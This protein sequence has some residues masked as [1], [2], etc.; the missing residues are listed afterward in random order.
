[1]LGKRKFSQLFP[2]RESLHAS[3]DW[4]YKSWFLFTFFEHTRLE[5]F[6]QVTLFI[7]GCAAIEL[8]A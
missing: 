3:A 7:H 4:L 2:Q 5:E 8:S 6:G 1:M